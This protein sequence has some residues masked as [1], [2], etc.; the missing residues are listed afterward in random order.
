MTE[1]G[2]PGKLRSFWEDKVYVVTQKK[3]P[4]SPVYEIKLENGKGRIRIMHRNLLLPCDFL[5]ME[6]V[7]PPTKET[8]GRKAK[9]QR[10]VDG[11]NSTADEDEDGW[12]AMIGL[13]A[14]SDHSRNPLRADA[15]DFY[16]N[17]DTSESEDQDTDDITPVQPAPEVNN[18]D[19]AEADQDQGDVSSESGSSDQE[20]P[21]HTPA[22]TYPLRMRKQRLIFTY[23]KLGQPCTSCL[24]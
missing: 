11:H 21:V 15:P 19:P 17:N 22:K 13:Q 2:G 8:K 14:G 5:P 7:E 3:Y 1:K 4:D 18:P 10:N 24:K 20:G 16:P 6:T 12:S 23:D 9:K